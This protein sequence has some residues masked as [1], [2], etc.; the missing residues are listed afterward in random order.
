MRLRWWRG[1]MA[2]MT[3][4]KT[5]ISVIQGYEE[6]FN[7]TEFGTI[8]LPLI[9]STKF[10]PNITVSPMKNLTLLSIMI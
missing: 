8:G 6:D 2:K 4:E 3:V 7:Y 5:I 9:K 10:L 1:E